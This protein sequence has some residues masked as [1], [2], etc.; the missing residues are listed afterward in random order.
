LLIAPAL[1]LALANRC[2]P[3]VAPGTLAAVAGAESGFNTLAIHDNTTRQTMTA[4]DAPGA[5]ATASALIAAGH[6]V[7][8]G[9]MQIDSAN[10]SRL[11]LTVA[12]AF[13]ACA[14]VRAAG[15]VLSG[16]YQPDGAGSQAALLAAISRYNTGTAW[17]GFQNGYVGRV[18][19]TA[20]YVVP[21]IDPADSVP[22]PKSSGATTAPGWGAFNASPAAHPPSPSQPP[23]PPAAPSWD[24]FP[25]SVGPAGFAQ[26]HAVTLPAQRLPAS[27]KT[28]ASPGKAAP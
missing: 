2:A 9:L 19:A 5:V 26:E 27:G 12:T 8:L 23:A 6:S 14:S 17:Q 13:D 18:V 16:D 20:K 15:K 4:L 7:D 1:F 21:E 11:G 3:E 25:N 22:P 24:V 10:L 28:T